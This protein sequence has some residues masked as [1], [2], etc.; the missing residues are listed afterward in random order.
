MDKIYEDGSL[1]I[2]TT[3]SG[4]HCVRFCKQEEESKIVVMDPDVGDFRYWDKWSIENEK[5]NCHRI[6]LLT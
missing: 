6:E 3:V 1:L 5:P 2:G 4:S